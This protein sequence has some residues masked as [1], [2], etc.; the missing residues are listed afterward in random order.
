MSS[1]QCQ[2]MAKE[3]LPTVCMSMASRQMSQPHCP[4]AKCK[5]KRSQVSMK[6]PTMPA[7]AAGLPACLLC[8]QCLNSKGRGL[9]LC[10]GLNTIPCPSQGQFR[11]PALGVRPSYQPSSCLGMCSIPSSSIQTQSALQG[12]SWALGF[13][14]AQDYGKSDEQQQ[15]L[16]FRE[17]IVDQSRERES[18]PSYGSLPYRSNCAGSSYGDFMQRFAN[19]R[20]TLGT[21]VM[22]QGQQGLLQAGAVGGNCSADIECDEQCGVNTGCNMACSRGKRQLVGQGA[23]K[24]PPNNL[25]ASGLKI[26]S[27]ERINMLLTFVMEVLGILVFFAIC[28]LTF[29]LTLGYYILQLLLDLKNADRNVQM[30]LVVAFSV[31]LLAFAITVVT[32]DTCTKTCPKHR[33]KCAGLTA[34]SAPKPAPP[35]PSLS[36]SCKTKCSKSAA[37]RITPNSLK[38]PLQTAKCKGKPKP[39]PKPMAQALPQI[40]CKARVPP[41]APPKRKYTDCQGRAI[42]QTSRRTAIL[43][44]MKQPP[45]WIVWL[46]EYMQQ[47]MSSA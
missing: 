35:A 22:L 12:E 31:L 29:W 39:K 15:R 28:T 18:L 44:E 21:P 16:F 7:N 34:S 14:D 30:A 38:Q 26:C 45:T 13:M 11:N 24:P 5:D 43:T 4:C 23:D 19:G 6:T 1:S 33:T 17:T 41:A 27:N 3:S 42:F 20:D 46:R 25:R 32:Q 36:S 37:K 47:A 40:K 10:M 8:G 2:C 9:G